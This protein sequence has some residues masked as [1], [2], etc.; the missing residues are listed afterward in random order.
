MQNYEEIKNRIF[1]INPK[2]NILA[3]SKLQSLEKMKALYDQGQRHFAENYVQ[4]ALQ[5]IGQLNELKIQWH[6]IGHLQKNKINQI[7]GHF[8]W[9]HSIDSLKLAESLNHR[10]VTKNL[11]QKIFLQVNFAE[12][13][14]KEGFSMAEL[15]NVIPAIKNCT[16]LEVCGLMTMPPLADDPEKSRP[17]FA[18]ARKLKDEL[19]KEFPHLTELSMGTSSD[20]TVAAEEGSTWIRLG[21]VLFGQR[22]K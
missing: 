2:T 19:E 10:L 12:E 6:L 5:K 9:I 14:S 21:T 15:E 16:Q 1:K 18:Q 20:Y 13:D 8:P 11:V 7:L 4:E 17:F 3:V 22:P